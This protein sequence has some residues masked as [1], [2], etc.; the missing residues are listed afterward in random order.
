MK[1][2][3]TIPSIIAFVLL[4][5]FGSSGMYKSWIAASFIV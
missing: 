1:I 5:T 4:F 3:F 2:G